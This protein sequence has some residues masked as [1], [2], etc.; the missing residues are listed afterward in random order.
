MFG[1]L[2]LVLLAAA[3]GIQVAQ[4]DFMVYT[5]PPIPITAVP[6]FAAPSDAASWT[7]SVFLNARLAY[8]RFTSS[9]GEPYQSS[10]TSAR[11]EIDAWVRT[12]PSNFT[13]PPEVTI[14]SET[15]TYFSKPDWYDALPTG[16]RAFKEQ[17]VADQFSIVRSVIAGR[18]PTSSSS[19]AGAAPTVAPQWMRKE[20]GVLAGVAVAA[21]L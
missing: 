12:A 7:T 14:A 18:G 4:A 16:A 17:Q 21:F 8:G 3:A 5:E 19:S 9:L 15:P 11:S 2:N 6:S 1:E 13:I 10:L 20:F